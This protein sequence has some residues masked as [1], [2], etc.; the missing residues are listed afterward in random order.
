MKDIVKN[1]HIMRLI[2]LFI[3][4]SVG[5]LFSMRMTSKGMAQTFAAKK[6]MLELQSKQQPISERQ[7][8]QGK[9]F[10]YE[11]GT[12]KGISVPYAQLKDSTLIKKWDIDLRRWIYRPVK[13]ISLPYPID[14]IKVVF[15][16]SELKK[17]TWD[18]LVKIIQCVDSISIQPYPEDKLL[19]TP[20]FIDSAVYWVNDIGDKIITR[21][22][23]PDYI[24]FEQIRNPLVQ[25]TIVDKVLSTPNNFCQKFTDRYNRKLGRNN[26]VDEVFGGLLHA[27]GF[28]AKSIN[29]MLNDVKYW[30]S[31]WDEEE[32]LGSKERERIREQEE[33]A[34]K[35]FWQRKKWF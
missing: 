1:N 2:G 3:M 9:F 28:N 29:V 18:Q 13:E 10:V 6:M 24:V 21:Q 27:V 22:A 12:S 35:W 4:F 23:I 32:E 14:I 11:E 31:G 5:N 26:S 8:E 7:Y 20:L 19:L 16:V 33:E 30:I 25:Q 34:K 17:L 15:G